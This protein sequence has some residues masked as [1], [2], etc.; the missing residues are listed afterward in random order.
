MSC[1]HCVTVCDL[2][3]G[4]VCVNV[5][6]FNELSDLKKKKSDVTQCRHTE[7]PARAYVVCL[8]DFGKGHR[9]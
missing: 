4:C 5:W 1:V 9:R 6:E 8:F 7:H 2:D 3:N